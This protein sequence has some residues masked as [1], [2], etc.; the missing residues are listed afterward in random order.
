MQGFSGGAVATWIAG[1]VDSRPAAL[2]PV[3]GTGFLDLAARATPVPG[4]E[5]NLLAAMTVPQTIDGEAWA[6]FDRWLDPKNFIPT[7]TA[8]TLLINGAQDEFFPC[9]ST[10]ASMG[11][12]LG[13]DHRIFLIK[14]WDHGPIAATVGN[15]PA[16]V[17]E[18]TLSRWADTWLR[19]AP[20]PPRPVLDSVLPWT[21]VVPD[22]PWLIF[23][24]TA[25]AAHLEEDPG[26]D[27][28]AAYFHWSVDGAL[29]FQTWNLQESGGVWMAEVGTMDGLVF[30][31]ANTVW[32]VEFELRDDLF[33]ASW[34]LTTTP[35]VPAVWSPNI[36]PMPAR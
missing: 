9:N 4:W 19:G 23:S 30:T 21:C 14:D 24:C 8:P 16:Q 15:G 17:A 32:F 31:D 33:S 34:K 28:V 20:A 2:A 10:A 5:A 1:G 12:L 18:E 29:T 36:I 11:A 22:A 25:V 7:I 3:S 26:V 27:V 35:H 6:A 13:S